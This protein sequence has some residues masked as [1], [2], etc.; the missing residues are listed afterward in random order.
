MPEDKDQVRL[1][2]PWM[3]LWWLFGVSASVWMCVCADWWVGRWVGGW[4]GASM[5]LF[6]LTTGVRDTEGGSTDVHVVA[7][8]S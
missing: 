5:I 2:D 8:V 1:S 7:L 4:V 6:L 3:I